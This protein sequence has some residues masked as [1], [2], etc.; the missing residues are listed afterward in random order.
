[1][2]GNKRF[3]MDDVT[4]YSFIMAG[5]NDSQKC[6]LELVITA[7]STMLEQGNSRR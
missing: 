3:K 4:Y 2:Q 1:M 6:T 5:Y 7:H